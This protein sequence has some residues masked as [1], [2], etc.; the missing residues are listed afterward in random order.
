MGPV[1]QRSRGHKVG[2]NRVE[3]PYHKVTGLRAI[4]PGGHTS[5]RCK[6]HPVCPYLLRNLT[7][8]RP[9]QVRAT[10]ITY[11]PMERGHVYLVAIV[12][13]Y[14]RYVVNWSV[15][16]GMDSKW[17]QQTLEEATE[18]HGKP[19]ITNTGQGGRFT[20]EGFGPFV[21]DQDIRPSA[22]GKGRATDSASIERPWRNAEHEKIYLNPP[23]DG[24]DPYLID[25]G[26]FNYCDHERRHRSI[27]YQKP[28]SRYQAVA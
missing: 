13:L 22:D 5:R 28:A 21:L 10:D 8:D 9:E 2:R 6:S 15:S 1:D 26:C 11:I 7:I 18:M 3:R 4:M 23:R 25:N 24:L 20:S 17:C 27:H 12:D 16:N 19:E 14:G